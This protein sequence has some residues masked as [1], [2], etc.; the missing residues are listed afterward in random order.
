MPISMISGECGD[1]QGAARILGRNSAFAGSVPAP[2]SGRAGRLRRSAGQGADRTDL[3]RPLLLGHG[4]VHAPVLHL[5][6]AA[7]GREPA[8]LS[9][10]HPRQGACSGREINQ[11]GALFPWRTINGEEASANYAAGTAQYHINA[12]IAHGIVKYVQI[13]G[14][15]TFMEECGAEMLIETAPVA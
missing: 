11:K 10:Q 13:G 4:Y 2:A 1:I 3:R 8:A 9:L 12:A 6:G 14:D 5:H 15:Q 7:P